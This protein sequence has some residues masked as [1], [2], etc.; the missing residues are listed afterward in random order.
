MRV[1]LGI[2]ALAAFLAMPAAGAAPSGRIV[3]LGEVRGQT[4]LFSIRPDGSGLTRLT[5]EPAY[6]H[7]PT[8][9]P[10][11]RVIASFG[12]G[13]VVIRGLDG[14]VLRR[15]AVPVEGYLEELE[16]SPDGRWLSYLVE[17][18]SYEDPRG[19]VI[20][21]CGDLWVVR[22]DGTG[23]RRLLDRA[24]DLLDGGRSYA[25]SPGG[26]RLVYEALA[27]GPSFLGV[28]DLSTGQRGVIAGTARAVDPSWSPSVTIAFARGRDLF[29]VRAD[30]SRLRRLARA[31][32][33]SRPTWSPDRRRVAY[34]SAERGNRWGVRVV[35]A[36][37]RSRRRI[38]AATDDRE[39][40][41]SSD[42]TR[43]LW[44]NSGQ[45]LIVARSDR[46]GTTR[47][48]TRGADPDWR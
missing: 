2:A 45:R 4:E 48:L 8:W 28:V 33:V 39:L 18:C 10:D 13:G 22:T 14:S 1:L 20:P 21:P 31:G 30:G 29:V 5:H 44:E 41:W 12:A 43:L 38:G 42:A 23:G 27:S 24:V 47:F 15:I 17:H 9:S 37:G 32:A 19:Y 46:P 36:D 16:W 34:L 6:D 25:W 11:G 26:G 3:F 7:A 35:R 40:V